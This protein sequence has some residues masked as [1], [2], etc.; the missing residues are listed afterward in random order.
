MYT[1]NKKI[2][3]LVSKAHIPPAIAIIVML[4]QFCRCKFQL[5]LYEK[6]RDGQKK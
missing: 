5:V 1:Q 6:E 2:M 4:N 3:Q